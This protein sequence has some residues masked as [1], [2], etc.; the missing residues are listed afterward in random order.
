MNDTCED[1]VEEL[2]SVTEVGVA[3]V[4]VIERP[5]VVDEA[6]GSTCSFED[7]EDVGVGDGRKRRTEVKEHEERRITDGVIWI[8]AGKEIGKPGP[9]IESNRV[10]DALAPQNEAVL[11]VVGPVADGG[12]NL[13]IDDSGYGFVVGVFKTEWARVVGSSVDAGGGVVVGGALREK[14]SE[15]GVEIVR[16]KCAA[17]HGVLGA[18]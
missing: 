11:L 15:A 18:L 9:G 17:H 16:G 4:V 6:S 14:D 1:H 8:L 3:C 7:D 13:A 10:V 12:G 5:E 2:G